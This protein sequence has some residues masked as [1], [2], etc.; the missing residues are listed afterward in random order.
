[1]HKSAP[2]FHVYKAIRVDV[3]GAAILIVPQNAPCPVLLY[4][5]YL[6]VGFEDLVCTYR[7]PPQHCLNKYTEYGNSSSKVI[8]HL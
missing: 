6:L 5:S 4:H 1:M 8:N 3:D 2:T 7:S